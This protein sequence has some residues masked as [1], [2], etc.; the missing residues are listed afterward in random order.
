M[1]LVLRV[2]LAAV[3]VV[4]GVAKLRDPAG[5]QRTVGGVGVPPGYA[6]VRCIGELS[7]AVVPP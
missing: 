7:V 6:L 3:F 2:G 5:A 4:A 1:G